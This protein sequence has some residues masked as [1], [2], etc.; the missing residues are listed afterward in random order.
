MFCAAP[1]SM[2]PEKGA[3]KTAARSWAAHGLP[4]W[5]LQAVSSLGFA[6]PTPVQQAV[7][8]LFL[9]NSDV[10]VEAP[11]GSGKTIS[12]LLPVCARI[13]RLEPTR[14]HHVAAVIVSPTRELAVQIHGVLL[15]L[16]AFHPPSAAVLPYL[17]RHEADERRPATSD[18]V[19]VPQ[20][21]VGGVGKPATDLAFFLRHSPN[22]L[23]A[24][25]GAPGRAPREPA[26][27]RDRLLRD[28]GSG[29]GRPHP[30]PG[31]RQRPA[32]HP[33]L[34]AQAAPHRPVLRLRHRRPVRD[35]QGEPAEPEA[36]RRPRPHQGRRRRRGEEDAA[37]LQMAYLV[38]PPTHKIPALV[39]LLERL[40]PRP[41]RSIVFISC[42]YSV[43]C[44]CAPLQKLPSFYPL[45]DWDVLD[46]A[47]VLPSILPD[48]FTA[49][50]L[51]GKME[52]GGQTEGV[53]QVRVV[54]GPLRP[55][56]DG[57]WRRAASTSPP[58]TSS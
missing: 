2:A 22:C 37:S 4:E 55:A 36:R 12:Y 18:A 50:P 13:L 40:A 44:M 53:R 16:L 43:K 58:S 1:Q 10:V 48:G 52:P 29:R 41:Q 54:V 56:D 47:L 42:C 57:T 26:R 15:S 39:Q 49:I 32:A 6:E 35:H 20:L 23:V 31:L 17:G 45:A 11:T 30:R 5:S 7:L 28:A 14:R 25:P 9:A 3:V 38:V 21:V 33:V 19:V 34:R 24:T 8:P 27:Q 46:F 51:H